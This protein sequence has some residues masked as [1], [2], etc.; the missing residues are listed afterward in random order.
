MFASVKFR[1]CFS[2]TSPIFN[3]FH[4]YGPNLHIVECFIGTR[5]DALR[6]KCVKD[7]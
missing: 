4:K 1:T 6:V 3:T 5:V 7:I 2:V